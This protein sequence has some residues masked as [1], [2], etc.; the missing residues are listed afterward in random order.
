MVESNVALDYLFLALADNTRR[1]ILQRVAEAEMSI[2]AIA[3][4]Y[5]LTFAAISKHIKVLEKAHLIRKERRGMEQ[6]V[7]VVPAALQVAREHLQ[8]YEAM[9][10]DRFEQLDTLLAAPDSTLSTPTTRKGQHHDK[11]RRKQRL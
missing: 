11:P 5:H 4:F 8:H 2:G 3:E 1:S 6:I 7:I 9:W 10:Q